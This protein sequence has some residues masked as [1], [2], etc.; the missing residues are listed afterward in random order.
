VEFMAPVV[1][2]LQRVSLSNEPAADGALTPQD[3][4]AVLFI[5]RPDG[6]IVRYEPITRRLGARGGQPVAA[7]AP[8]AGAGARCDEVDL[9]YGRS[10]FTFDTPGDYLVTAHCAGPRA[11]TIRSN[12]HR[13]RVVR[14][15]RDL[16]IFAQDFFTHDVGECLYFEGSHSPFLARGFDVLRELVERRHALASAELVTAIANGIAVPFFRIGDRAVVEWK[17]AEPEQA[18]R[19][20]ERAGTM[21]ARADRPQVNGAHYRLGRARAQWK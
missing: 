18:L 4:T 3:G 9:T 20:T 7:G 11:E 21:F 6:R 2:E 14:P 16:D 8:E 10:G 12:A 19:F 15:S 5:R 1:V 13:L 17:K